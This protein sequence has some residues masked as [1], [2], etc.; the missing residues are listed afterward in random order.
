MNYDRNPKEAVDDPEP[1]VDRDPN[2]GL[3]DRDHPN[4]TEWVQ[5]HLSQPL[6]Q[7][8]IDELHTKLEEFGDEVGL[9]ELSCLVKPTRFDFQRLLHLAEAKYATRSDVSG[10]EY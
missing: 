10:L 2:D 5:W 4:W 1:I 6:T 9:E 7:D 8:F 3:L